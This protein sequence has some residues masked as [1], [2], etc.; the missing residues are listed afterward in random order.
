MGFVNLYVAFN[1]DMDTWVDFKLY[2]AIGITVLS[3]LVTGLF[4]Y[5]YVSEEE[6]Q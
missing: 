1:F 5:H 4:V 2:S 3:L 6:Q